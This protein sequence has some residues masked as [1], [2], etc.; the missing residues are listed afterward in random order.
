MGQY[1]SQQ[2]SAIL[3]GKEEYTTHILN[4]INATQIATEFWPHVPIYG[5]K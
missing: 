2:N 1:L 5:N 4:R 3:E